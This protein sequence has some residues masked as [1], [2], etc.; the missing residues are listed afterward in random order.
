MLKLFWTKRAG[1]CC[2]QAFE[3]EDGVNLVGAH[4]YVVGGPA[5]N[6]AV[7]GFGGGLVGGGE[8]NPAEVAGG[9]FVDGWH[10]RRLLFRVA[11]SKSGRARRARSEENEE[12]QAHIQEQSAG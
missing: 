5:E 11:V 12:T 10:G 8:F 9:M 1:R 7:E 4:G 3:L 2:V 6:F